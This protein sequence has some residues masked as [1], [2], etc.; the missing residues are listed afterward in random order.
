MTYHSHTPT[1]FSRVTHS[2]QS[3]QPSLYPTRKPHPHPL[4][5]SSSSCSA[6]VPQSS[7]S[8]PPTAYPHQQ[9]TPSN[10]PTAP[11]PTPS[12][13]SPPTKPWALSSPPRVPYPSPGK[14]PTILKRRD[15]IY[16]PPSCPG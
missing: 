8:N 5:S 12:H 13:S 6:F 14:L 9:Q 10:P 2:A 11:S 4:L 15:T 7:P 16:S 3:P 1:G